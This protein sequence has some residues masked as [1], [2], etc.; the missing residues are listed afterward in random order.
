MI[1]KLIVQYFHH[2]RTADYCVVISLQL[3][4]L[5]E[6]SLDGILCAVATDEWFRLSTI[7]CI[8]QHCNLNKDDG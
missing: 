1:Y 4:I 5:A 2:H 8:L 3:G 7:F 6:L